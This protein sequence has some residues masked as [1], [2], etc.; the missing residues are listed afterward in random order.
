ML[1]AVGYNR[2]AWGSSICYS[3]D[4]GDTWIEEPNPVYPYL[5]A[6]DITPNHTGWAVGLNGTILKNSNLA[7]NEIIDSTEI[8]NSP[9]NF[10]LYQNFPNPFNPGTIIKYQLPEFSKIQLTVYNVLGRKV[11]TLVNEERPAGLYEVE[12]DA[13]N[14]PSGIYFYKIIAGRYSQTRKMIFLK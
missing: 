4:A 11:K 8:I 9:K 14:L 6:I 12:F 5:R 3:T 1:Y 7:S 13:T 2:Y 10:S